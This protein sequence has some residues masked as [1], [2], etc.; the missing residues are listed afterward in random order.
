MANFK[1]RRV[2]FRRG[3]ARLLCEAG[4]V[5]VSARPAPAQQQAPQQTQGFAVERFYPSAPG[6][7]WFVMDDINISGGLGGAVS[8][9]GG[10][11]RNP[12]E[13]TSPGNTPQLALVSGESFVNIGAA[14][15]YDRFRVYL[16]IPVPLSVTGNSGTLGSYQLTA[17]SVNSGSNPDTVS[18]PRIGF[19]TRLYGKPGS[20][21]RL[22]AG[23]QLIFPSGNRADYVTDGRYRA[24]FRFLAAG[25]AGRFSYASQF[26]LHV[27]PVEGGLPPGGPNGNELLFGASVGRRFTVSNGWDAVVGPEFFGETAVHSNYS[28]QTG[29]E[30][31]LTG[32]LE[33][34]GDKPHPRFKLGI[35]HGLVQG[36]GTP[37][38]RVL[39]GVELV[40]QRPASG[41]ST[42]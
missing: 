32:R 19:D 12:L 3:L 31:L 11:A 13:V 10:Y 6:G 21:L 35:G 23:A 16:N 5:I 42:P 9:T 36:F 18:D 14:I 22:G 33:R 24:M 7:G 34:T 20:L 1:S 28:G 37:E 27:R 25:D 4:L 15:T 2:G 38:W 39:V 30:G 29:F 41:P 8:L 26:G 40:G 17:P